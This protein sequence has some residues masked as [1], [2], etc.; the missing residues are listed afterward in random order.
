LT[1]AGLHE[2]A[3]AAITALISVIPASKT[4]LQFSSRIRMPKKLER[5]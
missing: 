4:R 2:A 1:A 3:L 5:P